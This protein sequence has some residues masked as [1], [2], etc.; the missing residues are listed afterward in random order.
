MTP[1]QKT[2]T[3]KLAMF[4][5]KYRLVS[6][7][8][9]PICAISSK[10]EKTELMPSSKVRLSRQVMEYRLYRDYLDELKIKPVAFHTAY[11]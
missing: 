6:K 9:L 11:N 8:E 7:I 5:L 2:K 1:I 4:N 3:N 10:I